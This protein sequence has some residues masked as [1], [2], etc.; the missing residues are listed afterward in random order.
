MGKDDDYRLF[1]E[2]SHSYRNYFDESTGFVRGK[3]SNGNWRTP[4]DPFASQHRADDY[5]EGNAWQYTWLVPHDISGLSECFGGRDK[6]IEKLDS[7]FVL[8]EIVGAG[9]S[10]D[11]SGLIGQYAH[12]NEPGLGKLQPVSEKYLLH[13]ITQLRMVY[14]VMKTSVKCL[15]GMC[16]LHWDSI[17]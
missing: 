10:P 2:R 4:F 6:C 3:D 12:G 16:F 11:I 15:H 14:V 8:S 5:C 1:T 17:R 13:F 7:L 9:G